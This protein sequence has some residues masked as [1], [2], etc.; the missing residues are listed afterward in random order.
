LKSDSNQ[1]KQKGT[2]GFGFVN[3]GKKK[4]GKKVFSVF[5]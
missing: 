4:M 3:K 5:C 1:E 2:F